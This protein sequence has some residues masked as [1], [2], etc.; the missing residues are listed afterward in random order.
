[1]NSD[2]GSGRG[3]RGATRRVV[4]ERACDGTGEHGNRRGTHHKERA[5]GREGRRSG[6]RREPM[7]LTAQEEAP[8]LHTTRTTKATGSAAQ[9]RG[10]R[11]LAVYSAVG[12]NTP[13]RRA[14]VW[15][16]RCQRFFQLGDDGGTQHS[17]ISRWAV[18]GS[19]V[20]R[21]GEGEA[22]AVP[23]THESAEVG[24]LLAGDSFLN[25]A[26]AGAALYA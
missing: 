12:V 20:E 19:R 22:A 18:E 3:R 2:G 15:Y 24:F 4:S 21:P 17:A 6:G 16:S 9:S 1:V 5:D 23:Q 10:E 13:G 26:S 11:Q 8:E 7:R 14:P 25:R